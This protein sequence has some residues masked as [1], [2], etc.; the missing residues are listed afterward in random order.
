MDSLTGKG[1]AWL[2]GC[3]DAAQR[4]R[5]SLGDGDS[6]LHEPSTMKQSLYERALAS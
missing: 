2:C 3:V 4:K 5:F 1:V 6:S